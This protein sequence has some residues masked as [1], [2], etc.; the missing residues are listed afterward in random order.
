MAPRTTTK[1]PTERKSSIRQHG[2][3]II[4]KWIWIWSNQRRWSYLSEYP[5]RYHGSLHQRSGGWE[6]GGL[7]VSLGACLC[8]RVSNMQQLVGK[9]Q[10]RHFPQEAS[11]VHTSHFNCWSTFTG[12]PSKVYWQTAVQFGSPAAQHQTIKSCSEW[13]EKQEKNPDIY[14]S[15]LQKKTVCISMDSAHPRHSLFSD[16]PSKKR[17]KQLKTN[18][19]R[20]GQSFCPQAVKAIKP[21]PQP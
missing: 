20:L 14:S 17:L 5:H 8:R 21:P 4:I 1:Q 6:T 12:L 9:A 13:W 10:K 7:H 3:I 19:N 16:L 2:A 18:T 15:R 11:T